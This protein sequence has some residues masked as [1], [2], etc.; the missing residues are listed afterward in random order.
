MWGR[1]SAPED[2]PAD[3]EDEKWE[4][5]IAIG[6]SGKPISNPV[7]SRRGGKSGGGHAGG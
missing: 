7:S 6:G 2:M 4:S 5:P 3:S 1:Y